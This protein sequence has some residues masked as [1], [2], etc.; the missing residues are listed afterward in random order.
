MKPFTPP[1]SLLPAIVATAFALFGS[2]VGSAADRVLTVASFGGAYTRSQI[3]AYI[4]PFSEESKQ[5]IEVV[6]Y[7]GGVDELRDQVRS[8]NVKWDVIDI[9]GSDA[10]QA[11]DEGLLEQLDGLALAPSPSGIPASEDFLEGSLL[12]CAV[13]QNIWATVIA[14]DVTSYQG[15][16][17]PNSL[18]D[19]FDL[20]RFPGSRGLQKSAKVN[21]EWALLADGAAPEEIYSLLETDEGLERAL[22]VLERIRPAI[23]WWTR[24]SEPLDLLERRRVAMASAWS[25]RIFTRNRLHGGSIG[26]IWDGNVWEQEY[27]AIPKGSPNSETAKSLIAFA[28]TAPR[29]AVQANEI[30][31]SPVR[32]SAQAMVASDVQPFLPTAPAHASLGIGSNSKWWA[33]NGERLE[34]AFDEWITGKKRN[35]NPQH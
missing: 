13:G 26:T 30:A 12:P 15:L 29:Q 4:D 17:A 16:P 3:I 21:L 32:H 28:S 35:Y 25:G 23:V 33:R 14:Y 24:G 27:W 8:L 31:Y 22:S 11:C 6:D 1:P 10:I 34:Q 19:F 18:S 7:D 5:W 9:T 2:S 20:E